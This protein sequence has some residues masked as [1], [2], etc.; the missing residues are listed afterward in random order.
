MSD[1]MPH[2]AEGGKSQSVH[3]TVFP[4]QRSRVKI[5]QFNPEI[6][7]AMQR[8][9]KVGRQTGVTRYHQVYTIL[10]QALEV[11]TFPPGSA[12][13]PETELMRMYKVGRNTIR[14][15]IGRLEREQRVIRQRGSG[16]FARHRDEAG[17][18]WKRLSTMVFDFDR[19][20]TETRANYRKFA[21]I[22]TPSAVLQRTVDFGNRCLEIQ[23]TRSFK[24]RCF[25]VNVSHVSERVAGKLTR[26][27]LGH[28]LVVSVLKDLG[29]SPATATQITRAVMAT[30][31]TA[32]L[33]D[34]ASG[35]PLLM[36]E[37]VTRDAQGLPLEHL[38]CIYRSD[39]YP[40][41]LQLR[42]DSLGQ[43]LRWQAV[44]I[45]SPS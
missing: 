4:Q 18:S 21:R 3:V 19:F 45:S 37:T 5:R 43:G 42:Y 12:L 33:L 10:A 25:S 17:L 1:V 23:Q 20:A 7:S 31:E 36:T 14:R 11:G 34:V 32:K 15:A 28:K 13:P 27:I 2:G 16:T 8:V 29:H 35:T 40:L 26:R 38:E 24:G 41:Q 9:A 6:G 22:E 30:D 44:P 39:V